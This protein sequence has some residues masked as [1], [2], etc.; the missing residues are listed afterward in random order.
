MLE[1]KSSITD[2]KMIE[3]KVVAEGTVRCSRDPRASAVDGGVQGEPLSSVLSSDK[4]N[5]A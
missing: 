1:T 5:T 4:K 3:S 2:K